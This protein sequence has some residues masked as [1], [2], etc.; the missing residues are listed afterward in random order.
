MSQANIT[1]LFKNFY[2]G[3]GATWVG[4]TGRERGLDYSKLT[5]CRSAPP[6]PLKSVHIGVFLVKNGEQCSET[7]GKTILLF[8][9]FSEMVNFVLKILRKLT[10]MSP[11]LT[12]L[13]SF[14]PILLANRS[15]CVSEDFEKKKFDTKKCQLFFFDKKIVR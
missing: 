11:Y 15:K 10:K 6:P 7:Y 14:A 3:K 2:S 8:F 9:S 4:G 13:L 1:F 12:E 5:K